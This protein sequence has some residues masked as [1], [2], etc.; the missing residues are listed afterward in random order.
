MSSSDSNYA[1]PNLDL[2]VLEATPKRKAKILDMANKLASLEFYVEL[3][4][5]L[6][7]AQSLNLD[8]EINI[9]LANEEIMS[10]RGLVWAKVSRLQEEIE[11]GIPTKE[12]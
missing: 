5:K 1:D 6:K 12:A 7:Q 10:I 11:H 9:T 3:M 2:D 4:A 8:E